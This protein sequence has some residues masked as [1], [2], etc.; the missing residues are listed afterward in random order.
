MVCGPVSWLGIMEE[1]MK[2]SLFAGLIALVVGIALLY[3]AWRFFG[4]CF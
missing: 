3:V 4:D 2:Q 1:E